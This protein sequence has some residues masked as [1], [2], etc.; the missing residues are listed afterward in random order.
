M[1][2]EEKRV[3]VGVT[4]ILDIMQTS[5]QIL[6]NDCFK[7]LQKRIVLSADLEMVAVLHRIHNGSKR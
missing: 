4:G 6:I 2:P 1:M 5:C 7:P 3:R